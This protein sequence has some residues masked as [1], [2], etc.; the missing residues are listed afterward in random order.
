MK[1][2]ESRLRGII[3][4]ELSRLTE[5]LSGEPRERLARAVEQAVD[6]LGLRFQRNTAGG[7]SSGEIEYVNSDDTAGFFVRGESG[8]RG[9][10]VEIVGRGRGRREGGTTV[11]L[12]DELGERDVQA[13]VDA[14]DEEPKGE[15]PRE[16]TVGRGRAPKRY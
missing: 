4:E 2:T 5:E 16:P 12:S 3:R 11:S 8:G 1:L 15:Q 9:F 13:L 14:I 6:Y 10:E 7:R